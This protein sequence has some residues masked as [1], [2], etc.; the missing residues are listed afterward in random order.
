MRRATGRRQLPEP[1]RAVNVVGVLAGVGFLLPLCWLVVGA[2]KS[3]NDLARFPPVLLP[4][5]PTL[6]NFRTAFVDQGFT[7]FLVNSMVVGLLS[8]CCVIGLGIPAAY[9]LGRTTMTG[10]TS[11]LVGLLI[12]SVF[13][14]IAVVPPLFVIL[15]AADWLNSY[16]ALVLPY[17]AFNLPLAIWIMRGSFLS[18]PRE[19]EESAEVDGASTLRTVVQVVLP[20]A[21]P[22]IFVAAVLTF[23]ACWQEFLMALSFNTAADLQTVPVGISLFGGGFEL[24][25][26]TIFAASCVALLPV[27]V[28]VVLLRR[29]I[30][31]GLSSGAVK[32]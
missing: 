14:V 31:G 11:I 17:A 19:M 4:D 24:P 27:V 28:I 12:V 18:I 23:V 30:V 29:W 20:Q 3:P 10:R 22:G 26:G 9:A 7:G 2:F 6:E 1:L 16:Q 32:G 21:M 25:Y 13:P 8:T 15:R 5:P